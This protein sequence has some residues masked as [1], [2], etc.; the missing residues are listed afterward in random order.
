VRGEFRVAF[1]FGVFNVVP[2]KG[3][4]TSA[5]ACSRTVMERPTGRTTIEPTRRS[6]RFSRLG[7]ERRV[8]HGG[9]GLHRFEE[10]IKIPSG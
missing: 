6:A 1:P 7:D 4:E 5:R 2:T 10:A 9:W 3:S 8:K